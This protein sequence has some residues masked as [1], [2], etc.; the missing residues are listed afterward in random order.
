[1]VIFAWVVRS[2]VLLPA[3]EVGT[4]MFTLRMGVAVSVSWES[5]DRAPEEEKGR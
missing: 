5:S 3:S 1:M 4:S 2:G